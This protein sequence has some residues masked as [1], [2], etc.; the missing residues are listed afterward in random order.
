MLSIFEPLGN[1][2]YEIMRVP[3]EILRDP[4]FGV[5]P[6]DTKVPI[7]IFGDD[8]VRWALLCDE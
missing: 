5:H 4:Y 8:E 6:I 3:T 2:E 1:D 7:V